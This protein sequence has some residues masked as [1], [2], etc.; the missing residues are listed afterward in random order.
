MHFTPIEQ[1]QPMFVARSTSFLCLS[2]KNTIRRGLRNA[3]CCSVALLL[4]SASVG[5]ADIVSYDCDS[6]P[7][8]ENWQLFQAVCDPQQWTAD[9]LLFQQVSLCED[10]PDWGAILDHFKNIENLEG[11]TSWFAEWRMMTTGIS[12]ELPHTAPTALVLND[13]NG[14]TYHF[15][16]ADDRVRFIRDLGL[17]I[18][19]FDI[20]PGMRTFRVELFGVDLGEIYVVYVDGAVVDSGEAEGPFFNPPWQALA[21]FRAK[22]KF[23]PS[24]ATWDYIRWG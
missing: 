13:G 21:E 1:G 16:I 11:L 19:Y 14:M 24:T 20:E 18:L 6:A 7:V 5:L 10:I 23:V 15:T 12:E 9:G 17:P 3:A 2:A 8:D 4:V 22:S